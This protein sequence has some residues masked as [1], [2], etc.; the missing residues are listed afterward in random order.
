MGSYGVLLLI[1]LTKVQL[2]VISD[3]ITLMLHDTLVQFCQRYGESGMQS[4][5]VEQ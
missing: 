4:S 1:S 2:L 5:D 3:A